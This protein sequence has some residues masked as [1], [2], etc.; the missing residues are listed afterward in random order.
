MQSR[1]EIFVCNWLV[2][3][4]HRREIQPF[5]KEICGNLSEQL[6]LAEELHLFESTKVSDSGSFATSEKLLKTALYP[7]HTMYTSNMYYF[8]E[9]KFL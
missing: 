8:L 6:F 5:R 9:T 2:S 3:V 4:S 7:V 1:S